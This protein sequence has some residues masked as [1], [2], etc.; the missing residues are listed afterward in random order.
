MLGATLLSTASSIIMSIGFINVVNYFYQVDD[1]DINS[2]ANLMFLTFIVL[3]LSLF[4]FFIISIISFVLLRNVNVFIKNRYLVYISVIIILGVV[5]FL[6]LDYNFWHLRDYP[7]Q[8]NIDGVNRSI[9]WKN[10]LKE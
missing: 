6:A 5:F 4:G 10:L 2:A 9:F 3:P 8:T 7:T 1:I